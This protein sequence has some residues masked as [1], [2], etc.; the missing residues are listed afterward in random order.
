MCATVLLKAS[1]KVLGST[2]CASFIGDTL[3]CAT[4]LCKA[5]TETKGLAGHTSLY[6]ARTETQGAVHI[7]NPVLYMLSVFKAHFCCNLN[8]T[9]QC[10]SK[11]PQQESNE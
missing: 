8:M 2:Q 1:T 10:A 7:V 4:V 6:K 5:R 3:M 9:A 11:N